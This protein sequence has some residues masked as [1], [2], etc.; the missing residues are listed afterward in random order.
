MRP[1]Q[2]LYS[3]PRSDVTK[4][5][6]LGA[7]NSKNFFSHCSEDQKS[8]IKVLAVVTG[9]FPL[10]AHRRSCSRLLSA[11]AGCC[12]Q[13]L[14]VLILWLRLFFALC[15]LPLWANGL[16][17]WF[18][19]QQERLLV[20]SPCPQGLLSVTCTGPRPSPV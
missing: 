8:K 18:D 1:K 4:Y 14:A 11:S 16:L 17:P 12:W 7:F 3:L 6:K 19:P 9:P 20:P 10:K 13:L 15:S 2:N 5:Y